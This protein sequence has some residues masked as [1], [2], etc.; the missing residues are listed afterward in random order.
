MKITSFYH[1]ILHC[2]I[3]DKSIGIK[4]NQILTVEDDF[5][6][7]LIKNSWIGEVS[8]IG[9]PASVS[10][11][12]I[13]QPTCAIKQSIPSIAKEEPIEKKEIKKPIE[14]KIK[15]D[16]VI[17]GRGLVP[18]SKKEEIIERKEKTIEIP[19]KKNPT[20]K[21]LKVDVNI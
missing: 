12:E 1:K 18:E 13:S 20:R 2:Q 9:I 7:A 5:G 8:G 21:K 11:S 10:K 17:E 4:P 14:E 19:K 3:G 6:K 16:L 15:P